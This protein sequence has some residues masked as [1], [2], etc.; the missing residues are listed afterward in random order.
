MTGD[1]NTLNNAK[2]PSADQVEAYLKEHPDFLTHHESLLDQMTPPMRWSG[3]KVVDLQSYMLDRLRGEQDDLKDATNLLVSTTRANMLIQTRTH[4]S[5]MSLLDALDFDGLIP[6]VCFDLPI[7]LDHILFRPPLGPKYMILLTKLC[8]FVLT[9]A[10]N[11]VIL[12]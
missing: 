10:Q 8:S 3:D 2:L 7:L 11:L 12:F 6:T 4:A 1:P 5:V 9:N